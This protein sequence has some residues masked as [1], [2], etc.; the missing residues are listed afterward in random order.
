MN[1]R[2]TEDHCWHDHQIT[3]V[4]GEGAN[5]RL[6]AMH[7]AEVCCFCGEIYDP[8]TP[9]KEKYVSFPGHGPFAE[10]VVLRPLGGCDR[11]KVAK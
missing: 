2:P 9:I 7:D 10:P 1:R 5:V 3:Y 11:W 6:K 4:E 8:R